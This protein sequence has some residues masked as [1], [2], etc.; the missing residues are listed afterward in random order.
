[1]TKFVWWLVL[2]AALVLATITAGAVDSL[3]VVT[4]N[5]SGNGVA[6]WSTN[7]A[8]VRAI[9]REMSYL[10][11]DIITF[12]E[13][14]FTNAWQIPNFV[15]AF[16]PGYFYATNSGG[17][18]YI[19]SVIL[20]RYPIARSQS[21]LN[22]TSLSAFGYNGSFTRDL[23]EAEIT[24]PGFPQ[25]VHAFTTHLKSGST[26]TDA[27]R[28]AAEVACISNFLATV[29]LPTNRATY[30]LTGDMNEDLDQPTVATYQ[31]LQ[32]L[33]AAAN[34]LR[35]T[36]PTNP[37]SGSRFTIS[38]QATLDARF[39]YILPGTLL[40]SN[41]ATSQVF[42]TDLLTPVPPTLNSS[43]DAT[44]SDHLP[45]VMTFANPYTKP[46]CVTAFNRSDRGVN[47]QWSAVP[48]G[49][50]RVENSTNIL[51]WTALETNLVTTN[52][53]GNFSTNTGEA[54]KFFRVR[55]Q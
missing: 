7:S 33:T 12:Q 5:A 54:V 3:T 29:F 40:F 36:T 22:R 17:D 45:V 53:T 44:A 18:G 34:G 47:L 6:D 19:R 15:R 42:R 2:P 49:I 28:R 26:S 46:F 52:Y 16:L 50:Y 13:I 9:G 21:W 10:A 20:S 4:C 8:Q 41:I 39:D 32:T 48:G 14:P 30:F 43:D 27:Q 25:P 55:T 11:P 38:I 1:M 37:V 24:V 31:P 23:F 51:T 35:L